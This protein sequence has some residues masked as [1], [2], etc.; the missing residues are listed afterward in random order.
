MSEKRTYYCKNHPTVVADK[1]CELC[2]SVFCADCVQDVRQ[3]QLCAVCAAPGI[4]S[5]SLKR[6]APVEQTRDFG[7]RVAS[8]FLY[9][10][11]HDQKYLLVGGALGVW[12][13]FEFDVLA[14]L[15]V[16][17]VIGVWLIKIVRVAAFGYDGEATH[18]SIDDP[19]RDIVKPIG[20][21][22][23]ATLV[24]LAPAIIYVPLGNPDLR[25]YII[26][27]SIGF[28]SSDIQPSVSPGPALSVS[29][30][31][32]IPAVAGSKADTTHTLKTFWY[33]VNRDNTLKALLAFALFICP[34][35]L[36]MIAL[37]PIIDVLSPP[38]LFN[39]LLKLMF[40]YML[41]LLILAVG[42]VP[43]YYIIDAADSFGSML[44]WAASL[45]MVYSTI[46]GMRVFGSI[47][48]CDTDAFNWVNLPMAKGK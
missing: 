23:L 43:A 6:I 4:S 24:A 28:V 20:L 2:G 16:C 3:R 13:A 26:D 25:S 19:S 29:P 46:V 35:T 38:I 44:G 9:P 18:P 30:G 5:K 36:G 39:A 41:L 10:L 27:Q 21:F 12:L 1:K 40:Y 33:R 14:G 11:I 48:P 31:A 15:A 45:L 7:E 47:H 17:V 22:L 8:A 34:L 32:A 37:F 42:Y